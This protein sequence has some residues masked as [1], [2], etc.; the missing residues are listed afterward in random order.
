MGESLTR[1]S[2][3]AWVANAAHVGIKMGASFAGRGAVGFSGR[4]I[5]AV[6]LFLAANTKKIKVPG[7]PAGREIRNQGRSG[8]FIID[9]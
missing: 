7:S 5:S 4:G 9:R 2:P 1:R 6:G 3:G 8:T